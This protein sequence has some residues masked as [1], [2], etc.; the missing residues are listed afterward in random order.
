MIDLMVINFMLIFPTGILD[1]IWDKIVTDP[2]IFL[3]TLNEMINFREY[4][5][6]FLLNYS[7]SSVKMHFV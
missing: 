2:C 4:I 7:P 6:N 3:L 5:V 1:G